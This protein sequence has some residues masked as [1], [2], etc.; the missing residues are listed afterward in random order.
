M[1]A[2]APFGCVTR[3]LQAALLMIDINVAMKIA[4]AEHD[5]LPPRQ[6]LHATVI[7]VGTRPSAAERFAASRGPFSHYV[8]ISK[9]Q[10]K[11]AQRYIIK[12][13]AVFTRV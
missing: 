12:I 3:V 2:R 5:A 10:S 4:L 11:R 6:L 13:I 1:V 9:S 8:P 7:T